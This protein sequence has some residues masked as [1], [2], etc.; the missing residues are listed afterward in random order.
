MS[1][2]RRAAAREVDSAPEVLD[3]GVAARARALSFRATRAVEGLLSGQHRSPH[4]G[5]SV[6]FVEHREYRPGDEP[7]LI[8]WRAFARTDRHM[9]KRF[10][11]ETQLRA[12]LL[13]D[14]SGSMAFGGC[15]PPKHETDEGRRKDDHAAELLAAFALLLIHQGDAVG[16]AGFG[17]GL[18][19]DIVRPRSRAA[20]LDLVFRRLAV[21]ADANRGRASTGLHRSLVEALE[22]AG[23]RGLVVI[24]SD[25]LDL[26]PDALAP[27]A[28]LHARGH[29]VIVLHVLHSD[30]LELPDVG[31]A[32]FEGLEDE[33]RVEADTHT[34]RAQYAE[35]IERFLEDARLRCTA[36]GARYELAP[37]HVPVERV[38]AR[39]LR[40][41]RAGWSR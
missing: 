35:E 40:R 10:E 1:P 22:P 13:R 2:P 28:Q 34:A 31:A 21:R 29:M 11:Q 5:A 23:R 19:G 4:R 7:R 18:E 15:V 26:S 41:S 37:T 14:E 30:E 25:L 32:R 8:D 27:I 36:A 12:L 16:V 20:H 3:P 17:D 39:L 33:A 24:A 38:L 6:V 9:I